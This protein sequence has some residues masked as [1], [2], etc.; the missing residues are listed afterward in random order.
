MSGFLSRIFTHTVYPNTASVN[1]FEGF[2]ARGGIV[3]RDRRRTLKGEIV[4]TRLQ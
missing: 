2:T 1:Q 4:H 3:L